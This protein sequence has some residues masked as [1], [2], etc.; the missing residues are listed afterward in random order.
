MLYVPLSR[1]S[2]QEIQRRADQERRRPQDE[3]ALIL[4]R[5]LAGEILARPA[6]ES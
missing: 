5:A 2:L 4:E 1:E 6:G 3:A